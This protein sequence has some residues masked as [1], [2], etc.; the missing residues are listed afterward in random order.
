MLNANSSRGISYRVWKGEKKEKRGK[1]ERKG[2]CFWGDAAATVAAAA[3][4]AT[5]C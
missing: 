2:K 1:K 4:E 5:S 3:S